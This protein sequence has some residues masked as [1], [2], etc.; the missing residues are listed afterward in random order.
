MTSDE[1]LAADRAR[2]RPGEP[3]LREIIPA[4]GR[5][6]NRR[7]LDLQELL[8][9]VLPDPEVA[10]DAPWDTLDTVPL[11]NHDLELLR[12]LEAEGFDGL[13]WPELSDR[14]ARYGLGVISG[15]IYTGEI[16]KR[17]IDL[18]RPVSP[19]RPPFSS[20]EAI[21]VATTPSPTGSSCSGRRGWRSTT[22]TLPAVLGCRP[23]SSM[24]V[25][26]VS[27]TRAVGS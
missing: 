16:Y 10:G 9:A 20:D 1:E 6:G 8:F 4:D 25:C 15:L 14:L 26:C 12:A 24:G 19:V 17:T 21:A 23:T 27:P 3:M 11:V 7:R 22:G 13:I 5:I 18:N 2:G